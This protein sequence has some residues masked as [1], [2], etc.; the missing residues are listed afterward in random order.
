MVGGRDVLEVLGVHRGSGGRPLERLVGT[1]TIA[2]YHG[3]LYFGL[4]YSQGGG[5]YGSH[6][7]F[8]WHEG[9][10]RYAASLHS[11]T[12]HTAT[13]SV[14]AAIMEHLTAVRP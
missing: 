13:L 1:R 11:W 8:V 5:Q 2:G 4:P 3:R 10:L 6:Y 9:R 12:P 7:T 14:L